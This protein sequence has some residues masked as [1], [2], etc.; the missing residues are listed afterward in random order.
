[1]E[2][3]KRLAVLL[4]TNLIPWGIAFFFL[5]LVTT[6]VSFGC[7]RRIHDRQ[8]MLKY[9]S[10]HVGKQKLF[11]MR[12][13]GHWI[14]PSHHLGRVENDT[15]RG[16]HTYNRVACSEYTQSKARQGKDVEDMAQSTIS[17]PAP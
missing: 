5:S 1:M 11:L 14:F 4:H 8:D 6:N 9:F 16:R 3:K 17:Q 12:V 13:F 7:E 15:E 10:V 2:V